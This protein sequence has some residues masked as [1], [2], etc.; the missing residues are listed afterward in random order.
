[1]NKAAGTVLPF[2]AVANRTSRRALLRELASALRLSISSVVVD[3]SALRTLN[4]RHIDL[5]LE[6]VA[7]AAGRHTKLF[8]IAGSR[9]NRIVLDVT[10]ISSLVP[11]FDS[12]DEAFTDSH[13]PA[14]K[15]RS[16]A[17]TQP[18]QHQSQRAKSEQTESQ[19]TQFQQTQLQQ[20]WSS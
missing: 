11:I 16:K 1:M 3:L 12:I 17:F 10:R 15:D 5:L 14:E 7:E 18:E 4:H 2:P 13:I 6:C 19:Q 9:I 8:L 20:T